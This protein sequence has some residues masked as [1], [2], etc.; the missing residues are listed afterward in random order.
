MLDQVTQAL[1][2]LL[3]ALVAVVLGVLKWVEDRFGDLMTQ[4]HIPPNLQMVFAILLGVMFL[5]AALQ[6]FGGLIRVVVVLV[7]ISVAV[8]AFTSHRR[9]VATEPQRGW[10][11]PRPHGPGPSYKVDLG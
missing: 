6:I 11:M 10:N 7:L 3:S 1:V 8:H 9:P 5:I 4:A 2:A